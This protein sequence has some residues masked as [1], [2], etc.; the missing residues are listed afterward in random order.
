MKVGGTKVVSPNGENEYKFYCSRTGVYR[1][2]FYNAATGQDCQ[3]YYIKRHPVVLLGGW[4][5]VNLAAY[6][7]QDSDGTRYYQLIN[8]LG[9]SENTDAFVILYA[10]E[11]YAI[12]ANGAN[13]GDG[14]GGLKSYIKVEFSKKYS[15]RVY[16]PTEY[17]SELVTRA[18]LDSTSPGQGA[19][20]NWPEEQT[21]IDIVPSS[22]VRFNNNFSVPSTDNRFE[23]A[24][25]RLLLAVGDFLMKI[26][27]DIVG[28]EVTV[29]NLIFDKVDSVNPNFFD[30]NNAGLGHDVI[31]DSVQTWYN[32]FRR[33]AVLLYFIVILSIGIRLILNSTAQGIEQVRG[34]AVEWLK[35]FLYLLFM[36]YLMYYIF[37]LNSALV[38]MICNAAD[39]NSYTSVGS[40]ITDGTE[41]SAEAIEFRSPEYISKYTGLMGY[42]TDN[43]NDYYL[44]KVPDYATNFDLM[45]IARA[46]AGA[47][48]RISYCFIW[49]ILIGQLL[50]FIYIYYKRYFMTL[51]FIAIFPV[52]CIFQAIGIMKDGK[53]RVVS[54]WLGE[55]ISNV[56]TQFI[57]AVV[58]IVVTAVTVE[59]LKDGVIN[60]NI[61]NWVIIITAINF[62]PEGEK[63]LRKIL[64]A[65]SSGSSSEA[66]GD[67]GLKRGMHTLTHSAK[68][69]MPKGKPKP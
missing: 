43:S 37:Q 50:T 58:Y 63:I 30:P 46:Y 17:S 11:D 23:K 21:K 8:T 48:F 20:M 51:F 64:K 47:T 55:F 27:S 31:K 44:K 10:G 52:M 16:A 69:L 33:L 26:I 53:A 62:V 12:G 14:L 67:H 34:L 38:K 28:E 61:I 24:I 41:W 29:A 40:T 49:Y 68:Q 5:S 36:P 66:L 42:G 25:A 4:N 39:V 65:L 7:T 3:N 13:F 60:G 22:E 9:A 35:G 57:H 18:D 2:S 54:G 59:L 1:V 6:E 56:F 15:E 45:R 32:R 19:G